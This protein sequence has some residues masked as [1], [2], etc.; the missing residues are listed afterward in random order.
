MNHRL[1]RLSEAMRYHDMDAMICIAGIN[2]VYL[3]GMSFHLSERPVFA[4]FHQDGESVFVIPYLESLKAESTG[5]PSTRI[6]SYSDEEGPDGA[7]S[8][9]IKA[10]PAIH[11]VGVEYLN[12]RVMEYSLV[13]QVLPSA[14]IADAGDVIDSLRI[15]KSPAEIASHRMAVQISEDALRRTLI[16][17]HPGMTESE[18]ASILS[19]N[20]R[21]LGGGR[22]YFEPIVLGGPNTANPHGIP[23][24]YHLKEQD[25]LLIDFGT[26]SD[27]YVS[28]ITRTFFIGKPSKDMRDIYDLV[29][30]ANEAG[31]QS[32]RPGISCSEVDRQT[33][34]VIGAAGLARYF[35][36][37]TG[38]GIGM[39]IHEK[40]Y[41]MNGN[42]QLLEEGMV[43]TIEPGVYLDGKF[44]IRI[45]DDVFVTSDG[46]ECLTSFSRDITIL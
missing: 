34:D 33:R 24:E 9:A 18:I 40:P 21:L 8:K 19:Q 23:G 31:R 1:S 35:T 38:H 29:R 11:S 20:Q 42:N 28:D 30:K 10:I 26:S 16:E 22:E 43:F 25:I 13:Q 3:T 4:I 7:L 45:E 41:V 32:V 27:G 5:I 2:L 12:M 36:H 17:I 46:M 39:D 15:Q 44:G 14:R 6:F 37:R